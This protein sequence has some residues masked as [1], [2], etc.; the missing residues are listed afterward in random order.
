MCLTL[1]SW[2]FSCVCVRLLVFACL[3]SILSF[4]SCVCLIFCEISAFFVDLP[5]IN[6]SNGVM[7]DNIA[8]LCVVV[9][10]SESS[11][12]VCAMCIGD[13][14]VLGLVSPFDASIAM[15]DKM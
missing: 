5:L 13:E 9:V 2:V 14:I 11:F 15:K 8:M 4:G 1:I 6:S 7:C 3:V 10:D 12:V